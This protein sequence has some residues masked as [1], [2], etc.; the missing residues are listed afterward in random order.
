LQ[1]KK[2]K[3]NAKKKEQK[4]NKTIFNS[5]ILSNSTEKHAVVSLT[6]I[7]YNN[8]KRECKCYLKNVY[9]MTYSDYN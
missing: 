2:K 6:L 4:E 7:I 5:E 9:R 3:K 1:K 8:G